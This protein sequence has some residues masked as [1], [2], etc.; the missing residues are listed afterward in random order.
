MG[1]FARFD[2]T[3]D[4][5][6]ELAV[7]ISYTGI[8]DAR[9]NRET[10]AHVKSCDRNRG[11]LRTFDKARKATQDRWNAALGRIEIEGGSLDDQKVFYSSPYRASLHPSV[12]SDI[13]GKYRGFD[14]VNHTVNG[15]T[16]YQNFSL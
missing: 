4:A 5:D 3:R 14:E 11:R 10:E 12:G 6:I 15:W 7:G 1:A 16:Y 8:D 2:T 13:D 9:L